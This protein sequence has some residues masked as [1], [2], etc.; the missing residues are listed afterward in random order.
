MIKSS[1]KCLADGENLNFNTAEA[2]KIAFLLSP[3]MMWQIDNNGNVLNTNQLFLDF[4]GA[5]AEDKL[6]I[7]DPAVI[8]PS[9]Y[10]TC[11]ATFAQAKVE[12]YPFST[13]RGLKCHDGKFYTYTA[14]VISI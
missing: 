14:K 13:T 5:K 3:L 4:L 10:K 6:N 11:C 2:K 7:F 8:N 9:D 1:L 12:K